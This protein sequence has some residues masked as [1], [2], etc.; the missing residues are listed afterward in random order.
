MEE[1]GEKMV[2]WRV[3][4]WAMGLV[5]LILGILFQAQNALSDRVDGI[6]ATNNEIKTQLSQIQTDIQW[7][8]SALEKE[9]K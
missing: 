1:K 7:I 9:N 3:F 2:S 5:T 6:S 8:K 4:T